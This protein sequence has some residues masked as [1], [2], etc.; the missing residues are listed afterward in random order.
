MFG[1]EATPQTASL[2][3]IDPPSQECTTVSDSKK[4]KAPQVHKRRHVCRAQ[5]ARGENKDG[6]HQGP[7]HRIRGAARSASEATPLAL[8]SLTRDAGAGDAPPMERPA[9]GGTVS[10]GMTLLRSGKPVG[11]IFDLL[12][13][14][15]D[16]MTYA[17][18][19]VAP[20]ASRS[21]AGPAAIGGPSGELGEG[22]IRLQ[23]G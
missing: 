10:G 14:N 18:G 5:T 8:R 1:F 15:E 13:T 4:R 17:L 22:S 19:F 23:P 12:G 20:R 6:W 16:D 3:I 2:P 9:A 21:A 11:T 7:S